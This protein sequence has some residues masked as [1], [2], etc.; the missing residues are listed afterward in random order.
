MT[1]TLPTW[2]LDFV[3]KA[4]LHDHASWQAFMKCGL[5]STKQERFKYADFSFL[6]K[7]H[8]TR[9]QKKALTQDDIKSYRLTIPCF[10]LVCVDGYFMPELSDL[11]SLPSGV[12]VASV[13]TK[14]TPEIATPFYLLNQMMTETSLVV[15]IPENCHL[16][17]PIQLLFLA[18]QKESAVNPNIHITVGENSHVD[19]IETYHSEACV[20]TNVVT[21]IVLQKN[22]RLNHTKIQQE[23]HDAYHLAH[24]IVTEDNDAHATLSNTTLGGIFSRDEVVIFLKGT[25]ASCDASGF[26]HLNRAKQFVDHH[27]DINHFAA[28]GKSNML[29]KGI[30]AED[31]CAVFNGRLYVDKSAQQIDALQ[32]NHHLLLSKHAEAYAKPEL[33]IY[34]DDVKCKHGATTGQIDEAALFYLTARGIP[35]ETALRLLLSGFAE[36]TL[37]CIKNTDLRDYLRGVLTWQV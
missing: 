16:N 32:T 4:P 8:F 2:L 15:T 17:Q 24:L 23:H 33:E 5:P 13:A 14:G 26:Y 11:S 34:A 37:T 21:H 22:A 36:D 27:I 31:A 30:V 18:T 7:H 9:A 20:L 29:Y 25:G 28:H 35:K 3:H 1:S 19:L 10:L 6:T 12:S